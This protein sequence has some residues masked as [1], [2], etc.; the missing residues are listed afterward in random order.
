M[1]LPPA[2]SKRAALLGQENFEALINTKPIKRQ[3]AHFEPSP[4]PEKPQVFTHLDQ[5]G[6]EVHLDDGNEKLK[7]YRA[8][9]NEHKN[10]APIKTKALKKKPSGV[11]K[12]FVL[13]TN[14]LMHDPM[15]LFRFEEHDIFLPMIVLE[16]L[17]SRGEKCAANQQILGRLGRIKRRR[18]DQRP[19]A[20]Q[21]R[22]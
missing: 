4:V 5:Q 17:D 9:K 21:H 13:D 8:T 11:T 3:A 18:N 6:G 7:N 15:C 20:Q 19:V 1:P 16:E 2:P 12:L 10:S 14:V 22:A